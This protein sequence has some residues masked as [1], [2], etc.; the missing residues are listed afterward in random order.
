MEKFNINYSYDEKSKMF[1]GACPKLFG[2]LL[3]CKTLSALKKSA[4]KVL[5]VYSEN[6]EITEKNI[7][8]K[9]MDLMQVQEKEFS[10]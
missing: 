4:I 3:Y 6:D 2:F 9:D 5:R 7:E 10:L 1:I 8:F